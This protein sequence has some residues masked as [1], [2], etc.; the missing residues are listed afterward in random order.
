MA[1][2]ILAL[3]Q[4]GFKALVSKLILRAVDSGFDAL[5]NKGPRNSKL[6]FQGHLERTF[7]RCT[8]VRT[9][10]NRDVSVNLL[11]QY[12]GLKFYCDGKSVDDYTLIE[13]IPS[14]KRIAISGT[15]GGG[16]TWFTK[17]LWLSYFVN[18]P[19]GRIPLYIELRRLNNLTT[20]DIFS[21]IFASATAGSHQKTARDEFEK[22]IKEGRFIF[23]LDGFDEVQD[24]QKPSIERQILSLS[25][26]FNENLFIVSGRPDERFGSWQAFAHYR[27]IPLSQKQVISLIEKVEFDKLTKKKFIERIKSDL[28]E[29]HQSFLSNPLL[30]TMML[31]TFDNFADIPEKMHV[32][33]DQAFGTL[34]ARHDA[35]KENFKRIMKTKLGIHLFQSH[36]GAFCLLTY[37]KQLYEFSEVEVLEHLKRAESISAVETNEEQFY[38]DIRDAVCML[39][40]EGTRLVFTHR[41]FQEY[42]AAY[43]CARLPSNKAKAIILRLASRHMDGAFEMLFDMNRAFVEE[44]YFSPMLIKYYP[45]ASKKPQLWDVAEKLNIRIS[46]RKVHRAFRIGSPSDAAKKL[47]G[48][49]ETIEGWITTLNEGEGFLDFTYRVQSCYSAPTNKATEDEFNRRHERWKKTSPCNFADRILVQRRNGSTLASNF[50]VDGVYVNLVVFRDGK[51]CIDEKDRE[52]FKTWYVK[53][54]DGENFERRLKLVIKTNDD[55]IR[56]DGELSKSIDE[57]LDSLAD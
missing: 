38:L 55:L 26:N 11:N 30:A 9:I 18:S 5:S 6:N 19:G 27:V 48:G 23:I 52:E 24:D 21:Y 10:L 29:R 53:T 34:F 12:V 47:S 41:S 45:L 37:L 22:A 49:H 31:L 7:D 50:D 33:Y 14:L 35:T 57:I 28:Y 2:E 46:M 51:W 42:F 25:H 54:I 3:V 32:F 8:V 40:L 13:K 43:S 20:D 36:F 56:R 15:A 17:Y 1:V 4:D 39:M 44:N 16:K